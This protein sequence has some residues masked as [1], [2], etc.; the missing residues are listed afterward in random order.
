M[1]M[2]MLYPFIYIHTRDYVDVTRLKDERH[3]FR[4]SP[5]FNLMA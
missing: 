3:T 5:S 4:V 1:Q 2:V